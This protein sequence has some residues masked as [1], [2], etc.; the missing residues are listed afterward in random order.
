MKKGVIFI[1]NNLFE[2][3]LAISNEE[4]SRGLMYIDPPTPIMAF[5]YNKPQINKFWMSN[6]RAPLDIVFCNNGEVTQICKGEPYSTKMIGDHMFSDLI[7][8]F[9]YGTVKSSGIKLKHKV[10]LVKPTTEELKRI[11]AEKY[12]GIIKN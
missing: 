11:I 8:E 5:V 10:G 9:P 1:D 6:T 3:L 2:S 4:Q 7:I 12:P